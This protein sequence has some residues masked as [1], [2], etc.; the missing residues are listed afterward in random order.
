V[1][2]SVSAAASSLSDLWD[3]IAS[4]AA[5]PPVQQGLQFGHVPPQGSRR[6]WL[7]QMSLLQVLELPPLF[8]VLLNSQTLCRAEGC[9]QGLRVQRAGPCP[10]RLLFVCQHTHHGLTKHVETDF[11]NCAFEAI[12]CCKA[13]IKALIRQLDG[14]D[15]ETVFGGEDTVT[16]LYL[17]KFKGMNTD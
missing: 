1:C 4:I 11:G 7:L 16:Q 17:Q 10:R 9:Q 12:L 3:V 15:D 8:A 14:T 13:V 5:L 2:V 6:L